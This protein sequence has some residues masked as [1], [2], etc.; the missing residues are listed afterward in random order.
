MA[1]GHPIAIQYRLSR[2]RS[3]GVEAEIV[4]A[5]PARLPMSFG[6]RERPVEAEAR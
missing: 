2:R 1:G 6:E 5:R 4:A 3:G